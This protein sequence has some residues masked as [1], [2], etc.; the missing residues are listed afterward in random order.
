MRST[1]LAAGTPNQNESTSSGKA[2][3]PIGCPIEL[4]HLADAGAGQHSAGRHSARQ[5]LDIGDQRLHF[6][7]AC[8][9]G[10]TVHAAGHAGVEAI[11]DRDLG[12]RTGAVARVFT[13]EAEERNAELLGTRLEMAIAAGEIVAGEALGAVR[14]LWTD[15]GVGRRDQ[16]APVAHQAAIGVIR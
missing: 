5:K 1:S 15:V 7:S 12:P 14:Y 11:L 16:V 3:C 6:G 2:N 10:A 13:E 9:Q 4:R 8:R